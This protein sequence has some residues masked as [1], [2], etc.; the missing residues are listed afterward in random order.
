MNIA[1]GGIEPS[2]SR[3]WTERSS[4]LSYTAI[5]I[6]LRQSGKQDSNLRPLG[7][8]PSAL[9]SWAISRSMH[10]VGVEPTTFWFVV[11]HSIQL[12]YG[13]KLYNAEDRDRTGTVIT[14]R[15]ILSPVRLPIPPPRQIAKAENG[16]RTRDLHHGKV[17]FYL[18]TISA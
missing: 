16:I 12:R 14:Y 18:W 2:T 13:C 8:K 6:G 11:R 10:P 3:V 9:P 5:F 4:Q 15:G 1:A 17:M 7:P